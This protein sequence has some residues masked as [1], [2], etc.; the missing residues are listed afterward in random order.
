MNELTAFRDLLKN[1]VLETSFV[2]SLNSSDIFINLLI[3]LLLCLL[4]NL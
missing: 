2:S 4:Q 1:S 3:T